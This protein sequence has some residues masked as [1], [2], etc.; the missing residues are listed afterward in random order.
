MYTV[1][2]GF[3]LAALVCWALGD[4]LIQKTS[5]NYGIWTSLFCIVFSATIILFPFVIKDIPVFFNSSNLPLLSLMST[6]TCI[7]AIIE[8]KAFKIGKMVVV[9]PIMSF[10][11]P[12]TVLLGVLFLQESLNSF[13]FIL[14]GLAFLGILLTSYNKK[15]GIKFSLE[16]G[17]LLAI[18]SVF[19]MAFVN[20]TTGLA[21]QNVGAVGAIWFGSAFISFVCVI[22]FSITRT[23]KVFFE[24]I[25]KHPK[26]S[27][28]VAIFDNGAWLAYG[29]AVTLIP[30]SIAITISEGYIALAMILGVIFNK[31]KLSKF[32]WLGAGVSFV[33][34]MVLAFISG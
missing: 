26:E 27:V 2:I 21:S 32:Q 31:E 12:L 28:L 3:A 33:A 20:F 7:V 13:Q 22:Y 30:I 25:K 8:F 23:W 15:L 10:E 19:I 18:T 1:G 14:I 34:V 24:N 9:E 6:I 11:L 4:F 17:V 5:R 16:K 29:A